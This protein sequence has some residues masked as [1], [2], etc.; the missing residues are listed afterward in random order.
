MRG[1][2]ARKLRKIA[3]S[4]ELPAKTGY[5]PGGKLRRRPGYRDE[6]GIWQDGPPIPRPT[7]LTECFRRAYREAKKIYKGKPPSTLAPEG[8]R[9]RSFADTVIDSAREYAQ[10]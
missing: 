8:E 3:R 10:D 7:V 4:L 5:A 6:S 9:A 1:T 2:T